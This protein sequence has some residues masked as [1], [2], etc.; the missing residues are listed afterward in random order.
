M[1]VDRRTALTGVTA[2][3]VPKVGDVVLRPS[4]RSASVEIVSPYEHMTDRQ[5]G[6]FAGLLTEHQKAVANAGSRAVPNRAHGGV[7]RA[8]GPDGTST[9]QCGTVALDLPKR[10]ASRGHYLRDMR[11]PSPDPVDRLHGDTVIIVTVVR[12]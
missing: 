2:R 11:G 12:R 9:R 3:T 6:R 7:G 4:A 5:Y 1:R 8:G 10:Y